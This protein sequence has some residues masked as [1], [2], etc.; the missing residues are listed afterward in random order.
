MKVSRKWVAPLGALILTLSMGGAAFAATG[1]SS[2]DT[3]AA[4][5]SATTA[6]PAAATS[7]TTA[8]TA[9]ASTATTTATGK[10]SHQPRTDE[11]ALTGDVL[12]QVQAAAL[13]KIGT[14]AKVIRV[15]T[16]ADGN[17]KYEVHATKADGTNVTVYVD[18]SYNVVKVETGDAA[19]CKGGGQRTD[20][21]VLT[22]DTLTQVQS[23]ALAAAGSGSTL[24]R[25]ETDADGNAKYE[26]HVKKADG[27]YVTV[28]VDDSFQVV[29]T[30]AWQQGDGP[31][32]GGHGKHGTS[33]DYTSTS[34]TSS[35]S[36]TTSGGT[37]T[38]Q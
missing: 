33:A 19:G 18:G 23:V 37:V 14:D 2:T 21:T 5:T 16:D 24:V 1:S 38:N 15:E 34:G 31:R 20:E 29:K 22:G 28:Y 8:T 27:T 25:A 3:T 30:E 6:A 4:A 12:T 11:T 17:A 35:S 10:D 9:A 13:A 36:S 26:A 32:G 7:A